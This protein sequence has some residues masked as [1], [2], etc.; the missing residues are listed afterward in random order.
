MQER[1]WCGGKVKGDATRLTICPSFVMLYRR[2]QGVV[3][4]VMRVQSGS[5]LV[6]GGVADQC[7]GAGGVVGDRQK[8]ARGVVGNI[9]EGLG[10]GGV[11][12]RAMGDT[13][14]VVDGGRLDSVQACG[15]QRVS[16]Y[17]V[18]VGWAEAERSKPL[19]TVWPRAGPV[20]G[21][22]LALASAACT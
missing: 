17:G 20:S 12:R 21:G 9:G 3:P 4:A 22:R 2:R 15:E 6:G 16:G 19:V 5:G 13:G 1:R 14:A 7:T 18:G 10:R 11:M 8:A